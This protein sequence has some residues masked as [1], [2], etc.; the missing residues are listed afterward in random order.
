MRQYVL[1]LCVVSIQIALAFG[2]ARAGQSAAATV[3]IVGAVQDSLGRPVTGAVVSL[4]TASDREIGRAV[5]DRYGR[6]RISA[7]ALGTFELLTKAKG[8]RPGVHIVTIQRREP[9]PIILALESEQT[10]SMAVAATRLE[11]AR[12]ELSPK[13]G[14][15]EYTFSEQSLHQLPQGNNTPLNQVL[16]HAPGVAQDSYGQDHVRGEHANLQYRINGVQL[17]DG[18]SGFGQVLNPRYAE[19]ISLLTGALPAEFGLRTAGIIDVKTKTG[20]ALSGGD[21]DMYG[22]QRGTLQ[23]SFQ[24]GG[25]NG[26]F[27]YFVTGQYLQDDR[28]IE[29]PTPGPEAHHDLTQ[30]GQGFGYL[31]YLID[32]TSKL[33]LMTGIADNWFQIPSNP[34]QPQVYRLAGVPIYPSV[35][36]ADTQFEQ[37]Y[38]GVL[39][40]QG[41]IGPE[42]T[43][44]I[45]GF[46][47]YSTIQFNPDSV[48][49]LIYNG[50]ASNVFRSSWTNGL[51][52]DSAYHVTADHTLRT[53][54]YFESQRA[55]IDNHALTFP[56]SGG[57]Q[58]GDIPFGVVDDTSIQSWTYSVYVQ[59]EWRI[60]PTLTFNYGV[61]FDL[62]DGIDRAD[63]ASPRAGLVYKPFNHT[64]LHA[65][66]ARYFTPPPSELI[67]LVDVEKF[68]N[69]TGAPPS[70]GSS[71][72]SPE[73]AHYFDV[74]A[75]Q[76]IARGLNLG[77]DSYYKMA[78]DLLDEGQFGAALV[79]SPFNYA[80]GRVYGVETTLSYNLNERLTS[81]LNFAYS[82]AQG[83]NVESGQF[84]FSP[85]ELSYIAT[86]Y[87]F[88]DHDETF[89]AS[90]GATYRWRGFNFLFDGIY[91]SG[92]RSGFANTGNLPFYV[93][94]NVGITKQIDLS[95]LS[96]RVAPVEARVSCVN[97]L[98]WI[99]PIRNG[100]GIGV[101]AP[102]YGPRRA[103]YAGLKWDLPFI[104][105]TSH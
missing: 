17:P 57:V 54:F 31:S 105:P 69:T 45:S 2:Y 91:G 83:T 18:L 46:T 101:F 49:D 99:Y 95:S 70:S 75:M 98:D 93:Q 104:K 96:N 62:Y 38:F 41:A 53:G 64:T 1:V 88:L 94:L 26:K 74:G 28:G 51:Q 13:T 35:D 5:T 36:V 42:I 71:L 39:A 85:A 84:N 3:A 6:F 24:Y 29:P 40:Y 80:K 27:D 90:G 79:F 92:L 60:L 11:R 7:P 102:Q 43:Y 55:E 78:T 44:Q 97:L 19:S 33:T 58:T 37:N 30:Q 50:I 14:G 47:Y 100:T 9:A 34:G 86:H 22:G 61:R 82:V 12:N 81:Y 87:V 10:L 15:S 66:Y 63:Q 32:P 48:G 67:S 23:P 65:A 73:R 103:F 20:L 16:L 59:D 8:F 56:A 52:G 4:R 72:P 68:R 76:Q 77:I 89:T 25:S 21:V